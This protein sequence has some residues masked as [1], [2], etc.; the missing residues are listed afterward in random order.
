MTLTRRLILLLTAGYWVVLFV[1]THLPP[2]RIP[3]GPSNDKLNHFLA[4]M[5][6]SFLLGAALWVLLPARRRLTP[7][8]VVVAAMAYGGFDEFTQIAVGRDCELGDWLADVAG[9]AF[10]GAALYLLQIYVL[11]RARAA[12]GTAEAEG[13]IAVESA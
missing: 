2:N 12:G 7:L 11:R 3:R 4:Y 6:L 1:L 13:A 8:L 9:A 10:A 5:V